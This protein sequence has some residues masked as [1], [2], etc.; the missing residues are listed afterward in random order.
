MLCCVMLCCVIKYSFAIAYGKLLLKYLIGNQ[1]MLPIPAPVNV[2]VVVSGKK[3]KE[4]GNH[5]FHL[6]THTFAWKKEYMAQR[7]KRGS[8]K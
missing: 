6:F 7:K 5:S 4:T 2:N 3:E 1:G 8:S